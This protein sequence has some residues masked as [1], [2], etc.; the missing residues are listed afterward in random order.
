MSGTLELL[1]KDI[2][3]WKSWFLL[4]SLRSKARRL[5]EDALMAERRRAEVEAQAARNVR[6]EGNG[7]HKAFIF[8]VLG[9]G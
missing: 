3:R 2:G 6:T 1:L 5:L 8:V 9:G 4:V 7:K